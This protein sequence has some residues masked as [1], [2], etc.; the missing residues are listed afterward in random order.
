MIGWQRRN[1]TTFDLIVLTFVGICARILAGG[2]HA[3]GANTASFQNSLQKQTELIFGL[4]T[5]DYVKHTASTMF[6]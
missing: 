5:I 6:E 4:L 2:G 1:L 3:L